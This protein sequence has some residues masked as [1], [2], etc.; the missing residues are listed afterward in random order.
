VGHAAPFVAPGRSGNELV[1]RVR[2]GWRVQ[3]V[4]Y[5]NR[6]NDR[7][8]GWRDIH[9]VEDLGSTVDQRDEILE[10]VDAEMVASAASAPGLQP[11]RDQIGR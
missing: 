11:R 8:G 6:E 5:L 1:D 9:F 2:E 7:E 10:I 4:R 3:Q